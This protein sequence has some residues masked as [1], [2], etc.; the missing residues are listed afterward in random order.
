[1]PGVPLLLGAKPL[2]GLKGPFVPIHSGRW[3][4]NS[5]RIDSRIVI[6]IDTPPYGLERHELNGGLE[7]DIKAFGSIFAEVLE[8]GN[9]R[10]L[11]I[12]LEKLK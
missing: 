5:N 2:I 8:A 9:E 12:S 7:L 11:N 6:I 10:S 1:M 3:G 4:V